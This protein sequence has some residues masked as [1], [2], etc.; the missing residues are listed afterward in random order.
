MPEFEF[1]VVS[2]HP[3][4]GM[5]FNFGV[6]V[7][8]GRDELHIRFRTDLPEQVAAEDRK[9]IEAM[10]EFFKSLAQEQGTAGLLTYLNETASNLIRVSNRLRVSARTAHEALN[11]ACEL[12]VD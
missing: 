7:D 12:H 3:P 5:Q 1:I 11:A 2:V 9:V 4:G 8:S 6:I 10:P